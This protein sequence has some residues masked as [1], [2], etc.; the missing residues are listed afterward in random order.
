M[1]RSNSLFLSLEGSPTR[2]TCIQRLGSQLRAMQEA[3]G[4]ILAVLSWG[5]VQLSKNVLMSFMTGRYPW[6]MQSL[7]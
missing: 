3:N 7:P 4:Y 2:K 6:R 1:P 5:Y